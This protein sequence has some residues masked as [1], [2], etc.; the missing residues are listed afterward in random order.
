MY[1]Y[2]TGQV[3]GAESGSLR[4]VVDGMPSDYFPITIAP[5][6]TIPSGNPI[7]ELALPATPQKI[8]MS[9]DGALA[10][11]ATADGVGA[12]LIVMGRPEGQECYC[13]ANQMLRTFMDRMIGSYPTVV[14]DNEAGM[15]HISRRT[16]RDVDHLFL[17]T[18]PTQRGVIAV[19]RIVEMV[20]GHVRV[21]LESL[22]D[23]RRGHAVGHLV[24]IEVDLA[25]RGIPEGRSDGGH[26]R[27]ELGGGQRRHGRMVPAA[28]AVAL[29][30]SGEI[31]REEVRALEAELLADLR[32]GGSLADASGLGAVDLIYVPEPTS[33]RRACR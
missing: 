11:V 25:T 21:E 6:K 22:G 9:P 1:S 2:P 13:S 19:R 15:E 31:S 12:D 27:G 4:V 20:P 30:E 18:D 3:K 10:Y 8:A 5:P 23:H 7:G 32:V 33:V 24:G 14:V 17:V 16:T 26:R 28:A 29:A